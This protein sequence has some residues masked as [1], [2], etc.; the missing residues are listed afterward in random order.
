MWILAQTKSKR[1][2]VAEF[3]VINQGF[4]VFLPTIDTK[5]F[6]NSQWKD[7]KEFLFPGYIFINL[8]GNMDK[9]GSLSYT[10]GILKILVDRISG[11]PHVIQQDIINN[12]NSK[13]VINI[14]TLRKQICI[15]YGVLVT[16][17]HL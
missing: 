2:K 4:D 12:I 10:T 11:H 14:N 8:K 7:T 1:E 3:N 16:I 6:F 13:K 15:N 17:S 5:K 9:L